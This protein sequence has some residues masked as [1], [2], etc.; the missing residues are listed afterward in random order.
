MIDLN[1]SDNLASCLR[2]NCFLAVLVR[3]VLLAASCPA[4]TFTTLYSFTTGGYNSVGVFT[5]SDGNGLLAG[6]IVSGNK[7]YGT[8]SEGG[9]WPGPVR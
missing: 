9:T 5:N 6:L 3:G 1:H 7:I 8:A 2:A 4:Q